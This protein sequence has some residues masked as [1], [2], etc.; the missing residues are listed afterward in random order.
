[1]C[2]EP[3][4]SGLT[5]RSK[6]GDR[7]LWRAKRLKNRFCRWEILLYRSSYFLWILKHSFR[8]R[9]ASI[10]IK[11]LVWSLRYFFE[12][13]ETSKVESRGILLRLSRDA[14]SCCGSI[15][16]LSQKIFVAWQFICVLLCRILLNENEANRFCSTKIK[17]PTYFFQNLFFHRPNA[18]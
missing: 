15:S 6:R 14:L 17:I 10:E 4:V 16:D 3:T 18:S 5:D 7:G 2:Y 9:D 1:M 8:D 11:I 13:S 12:D